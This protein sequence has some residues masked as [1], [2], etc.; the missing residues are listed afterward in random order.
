[1]KTGKISILALCAFSILEL[2]PISAHCADPKVR[3]T[4]KV[5]VILRL[6]DKFNDTVATMLAGIESAKN[7]YEAKHPGV[8]IVLKRYPH[9]DD[10]ESVLKATTRA[11]EDKMP[12]VIG[13]ELSEESIV[14]GDKLAESKAVFITPTS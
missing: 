11:V 8:R 14:I 7:L 2:M 3:K 5:G 12:A 4:L 10:L 1:M 6:N 9:G 13:G